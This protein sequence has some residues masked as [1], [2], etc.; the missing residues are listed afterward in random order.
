MSSRNLLR[1]SLDQLRAFFGQLMW[2]FRNRLRKARHLK[3]PHLKLHLGCG[4]KRLPGF[5]NID[6]RRTAATDFTED[7]KDL[8]SFSANAEIIF[9]NAFFEHIF[10][11]DHLPHLRGAFRALRPG[12]IICYLGIPNFPVIARSYL[13]AGPGTIGPVFTLYNAYRHTHADYEQA[14]GA[15][16][17][18][19]HKYL[20]DKDELARLLDTAGFESFVVF[21]Y[22]HPD[23]VNPVPVNLGFFAT[24]GSSSV[25]LRHR[26]L[27]FLDGF[28]DQVIVGTVEFLWSKG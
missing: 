10:R 16:V 19:T 9:S 18:E 20:F 3:S 13:D 12:G 22:A 1:R 23:D 4:A 25:Q 2:P 24:V 11:A 14:P 26:C 27:A 17:E 15:F 6:V 28:P 5:V 21:Q 8:R 7:L